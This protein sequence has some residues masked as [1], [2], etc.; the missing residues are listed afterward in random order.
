MLDKEQFEK[1]IIMPALKE[2]GLYSE[3]AAAM[4]ISTAIAESR[5]T[6][7]KQ[8][9][10]GPALGLY[11][12]EPATH[13]DI[14]ISFLAYRKNKPYFIS[15]RSV[16]DLIWDL[17]YATQI[18]RIHYLRIPTSLP[19]KDDLEGQAIYWKDHYNTNH[20]KGTVDKFIQIN[21]RK[22]L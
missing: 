19:D 3:D 17:K 12:C 4:L 1:Y 5:L 20:G 2:I 8:I 15:R 16:N 7:I 6:Y 9:G 22:E 11:Q 18:C 13:N 21:S 14:H 10:N